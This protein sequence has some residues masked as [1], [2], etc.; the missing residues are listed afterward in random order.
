MILSLFDVFPTGF[1]FAGSCLKL[2]SV[3]SVTKP[4]LFIAEYFFV[5]VIQKFFSGD[6]TRHS[7]CR[8]EGFAGLFLSLLWSNETDESFS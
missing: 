2:E 4:H 1:C 5:F 8:I 6:T 7:L 3:C